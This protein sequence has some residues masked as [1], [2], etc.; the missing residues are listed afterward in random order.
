MSVSKQVH[1]AIP[2]RPLDAAALSETPSLRDK[3]TLVKAPAD[4]QSFW[5]EFNRTLDEFF[6]TMNSAKSHIHVLTTKL[7]ERDRRV[8]LL[9]AENAALR[10][11]V[12]LQRSAITAPRPGNVD[13]KPPVPE[14]PRVPVLSEPRPAN[15]S[16]SGIWSKLNR[17]ERDVGPMN[18]ND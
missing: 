12:E 14:F 16:K 17:L 1:D 5:D 10:D 18:L 4:A 13:D 2:V 7:A 15:A 3:L 11:Q 6:R 9:E 8:E